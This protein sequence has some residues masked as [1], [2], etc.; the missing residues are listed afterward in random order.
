M[1]TFD[2]DTA[3]AR[4]SELSRLIHVGAY[5]ERDHE[6]NYGEDGIE[7]AADALVFQAAQRGLAFHWH[8]DTSTYTLEALSAEDKAAFLHVNVESLVWCLT[9]TSHYLNRLPYQSEE[10]GK[11]RAELNQHLERGL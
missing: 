11:I 7:K 5:D 1:A 2:K 9:E 10:E 4:Y 6:G 8:K 3:I